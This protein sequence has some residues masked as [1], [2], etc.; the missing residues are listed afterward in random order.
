MRPRVKMGQLP[1]DIPRQHKIELI[2]DRS[3]ENRR[4]KA[5]RDALRARERAVLKERARKESA[6]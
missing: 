1:G 3:P 2:E 5:M 4:G 6:R